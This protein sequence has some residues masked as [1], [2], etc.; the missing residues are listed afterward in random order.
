MDSIYP[1]QQTKWI[2][3]TKRIEEDTLPH[4]LLVSGSSGIGKKNF[5]LAVV[6]N[7]LCETC[8]GK[9]TACGTCK[10]CLLIT[11]ETHPDLK[12]I[13]P[14]GK[15]ET[16]GVD[17]IRELTNY[18]TLT[19]HIGQYKIALIH[20]AEKMN[21]NAANSL[22][23]SLEEPPKSSIIILVS[24][25]P[26]TLIPTIRSRC[27]LLSLPIP[28][29]DIAIEWLTSK[30]KNEFDSE[31]LLALAQGAPLLAFTFSQENVLQNRLEQ[32]RQFNALS[33]QKGDPEIGRAHV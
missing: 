6:Q 18:V 22:L 20:D 26:N 27:Q 10:S 11:G 7:I 21:T 14:S 30:V 23:K 17:Q 2:E 15:S 8:K 1:W 28:A 5:S 29:K 9:S 31:L 3:V 16:I 33:Q 12:I 24:S 4:A 13:E 19:P 32:F 25:R